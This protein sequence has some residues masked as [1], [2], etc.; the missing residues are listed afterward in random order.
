MEVRRRKGIAKDHECARP[1]QA[2]FRAFPENVEETA[3]LDGLVEYR[4]D[5][6]RHQ[7]FE[8]FAGHVEIEIDT[9]SVLFAKSSDESRFVAPGG[10]PRQ[11]GPPTT[12]TPID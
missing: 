9:E 5:Q 11:E 12:E 7:H 10:T 6:E 3:F 8:I 1:P 4:R 2:L